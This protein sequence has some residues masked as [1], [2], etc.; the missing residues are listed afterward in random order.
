MEHLG[1]DL[2]AFTAREAATGEIVATALLLVIEKPCNPDFIN[3]KVGEVLNVYTMP[4]YRRR[5][6]GS[7]L[8]EELV[9]FSRSSGLDYIELGATSEGYPMY[10]KLGFKTYHS[11]YTEMQYRL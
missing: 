5:G 7:R 4:A 10:Q 9:D 6:I 1:R 2:I 11:R 3:G 8:I